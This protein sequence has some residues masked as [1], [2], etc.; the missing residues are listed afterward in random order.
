MNNSVTLDRNGD[1]IYKIDN[2]TITVYKRLNYLYLCN[3]VQNKYKNFAIEKLVPYE[4]ISENE[5]FRR[6]IRIDPTYITKYLDSCITYMIDC[7]TDTYDVYN[8]K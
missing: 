5:K 2:A 8:A 3:L 1:V 7:G 6:E 4:L